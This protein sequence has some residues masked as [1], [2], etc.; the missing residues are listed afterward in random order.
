[1]VAQFRKLRQSFKSH[2]LNE[3]LLRFSIVAI[4]SAVLLGLL[5]LDV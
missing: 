5:V 4:A 2:F 1:M 3:V